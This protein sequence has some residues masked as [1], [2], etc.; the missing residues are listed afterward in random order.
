MSKW[1]DR[2]HWEFDTFYLGTDRRG[3]WL[4]IPA[5][6]VMVR[7]GATYVAPTNQV[8]LVPPPGPDAERGWL[9]TFHAVGGPVRIYV[10]VTTPPVWDGSTV[11]A[12]D[13]DLDIVLGNSGRVWVDDEDEFA[14]H[15]TRFGYPDDVT[16]AAMASCDWVH[17]LVAGGHAPYDGSASAWLARLGGLSTR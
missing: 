5:G 3:D 14:D 2:P 11:R 10:D 8:G 12:V 13:L 6:T 7:P 4:G 17:E 1:G 9:A 16:A 15:R